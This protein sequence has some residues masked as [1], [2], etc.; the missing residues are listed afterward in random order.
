MEFYRIWWD[1]HSYWALGLPTLPVVPLRMYTWMGVVCDSLLVMSQ[2]LPLSFEHFPQEGFRS[3]VL[4]SL[5]T[6]KRL[7][8]EDCSHVQEA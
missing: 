4:E 3:F 8:V 1:K 6:T 5:L 7:E 2:F